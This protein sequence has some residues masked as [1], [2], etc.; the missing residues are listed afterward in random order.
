MAPT[1]C[2]SSPFMMIFAS[3][4]PRDRGKESQAETPGLEHPGRSAPGSWSR[5]A[6]PLGSRRDE[7]PAGN[8]A[9]SQIRPRGHAFLMPCEQIPRAKMELRG[10]D[11]GQGKRSVTRLLVFRRADAHA[12]CSALTLVPTVFKTRANLS[13]SNFQRV[14]TG[15]MKGRCVTWHSRFSFKFAGSQP[16]T[17]HPSCERRP[18]NLGTQVHN[19]GT[20]TRPFV[21]SATPIRKQRESQNRYLSFTQSEQLMRNQLRC[22]RFMLSHLQ[23]PYERVCEVEK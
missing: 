13:H 1:A 6:S 4:G 19:R 5:P 3:A 18:I 22:A 8:A 11:G 23:P 21:S 12:A 2:A 20:R 17:G 16:L 15:G 9:V 14:H 7:E 10:R